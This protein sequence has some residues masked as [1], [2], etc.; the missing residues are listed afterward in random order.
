MMK[1]LKMIGSA[2]SQL[3]NVMTAF[4][5]DNTGPNESVSA[6]AHRQ[7]LRIESFINFVFFWQTNHC[8]QSYL[9]DV[10]DAYSLIDEHEAGPD[11][12]AR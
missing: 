4:D 7:G 6:R 8:E 3:L 5:L 1:R 9:S 2:L 12:D 10:S 11:T